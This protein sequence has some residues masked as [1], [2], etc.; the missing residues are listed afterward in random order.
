M[1]SSGTIHL[2]CHETGL[3]PAWNSP[4][5]LGW[6]ASK[7]QGSFCLC[8]PALRSR[9]DI[10]C[11]AFPTSFPRLQLSCSCLSSK[12]FFPQLS[13]LPAPTNPILYMME[14]GLRQ[15][16]TLHTSPISN[17]PTVWML[18][19]GF[20]VYLPYQFL[21]STIILPLASPPFSSAFVAAP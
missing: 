1:S 18:K 5:R 11:P 3:S 13:L 2:V 20:C 17:G 14:L 19:R 4:N 16:E 21:P 15:T 8:S 10:K 6:P 7:Y 9:T 12:H